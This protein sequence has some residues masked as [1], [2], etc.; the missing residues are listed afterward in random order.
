[1]DVTLVRIKRLL[2][3]GKYLFSLKAELELLA[4]DLA[5]ADVVEAIMNAP[6]VTKVLRSR[7]GRRGAPRERLFVIVG[8]TFDGLLLYTKG[9]IRRVAGEDTYYFLVSSKRW[10]ADDGDA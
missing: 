2:L 6:A 10:A 7:S 1:M 9:T 5:A 4:D 8:S 3:A